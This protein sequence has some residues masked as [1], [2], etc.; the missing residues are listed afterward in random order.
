MKG[1]RKL[2]SHIKRLYLEEVRFLFS[3]WPAPSS[4]DLDALAEAF[5]G[6]ALDSGAEAATGAAAAGGSTSIVSIP[7]SSEDWE[8]DGAEEDV[9][10]VATAPDDDEDEDDDVSMG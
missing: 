4:D 7:E 5:T 10:A 6:L 1:K 8:R 2:P 9:A 3:R